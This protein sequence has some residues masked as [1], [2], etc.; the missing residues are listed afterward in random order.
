M[1]AIVIKAEDFQYPT[2]IELKHVKS[3]MPPT[4]GFTFPRVNEI[5]EI[6]NDLDNMENVARKSNLHWWNHCLIN[7]LGSLR[8]A[9]S[10]SIVHFNRG[11]PDDLSVYTDRNFINRT[12]FSYYGETYFYFFISVEDT[13]A[14]LVNIY[15]SIK[16]PE[17]KVAMNDAL[18]T[19]I[20]DQIVKGLCKQL[21]LDTRLTK[22]FRNTMAHRF[23]LTQPDYRPSIN[24]ENGMTFEARSSN[25]ISPS[26]LQT[27]IV[28]SYR[29]MAKFLT[30]LKPI[31]K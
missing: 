3:E 9:Y 7:R 20:P 10:N 29:C 21:V 1:A 4:I 16:I 24:C 8:R 17:H 5:V 22:E 15:F 6:L 14:H 28:R 31:L 26:E 27:E 13:I 25:G 19:K 12:Q 2:S 23:L 30:D 11:V 18:V